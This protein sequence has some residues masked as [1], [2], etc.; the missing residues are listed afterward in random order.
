MKVINFLQTK[1]AFFVFLSL[2][3]MPGYTQMKSQNSP[4]DLKS[5]QIEPLKAREPLSRPSTPSKPTQAVT[6]PVNIPAPRVTANAFYFYP[7]LIVNRQGSWRG[8]DNLLNLSS[9]IGIYFTI[10][11]PEST[12]L[13][14]D[15]Q[16]LKA[17]CESIFQQAGINP[18]ILVAPDQ[19]PLPFF[20]FQILIYPIKEGYVASC[21]G[22]LFESVGLKR[23]ELDSTNMAFQAVTWQKSTLIVSPTDKIHAQIKLNVENIAQTFAGVYQAF[24]RNRGSS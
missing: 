1:F 14:I 16:Q 21:E 22:R 23:I 6:L 11:K 7:G 12:L 20:E 13:E 19:P 3:V 10:S 8:G 15:Q 17:A 24:E 5:M 18:K 4:S 9:N 2:S